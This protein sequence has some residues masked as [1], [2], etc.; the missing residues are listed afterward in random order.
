M[1]LYAAEAHSR[2]DRE[3]ILLSRLFGTL[4][5]LDRETYLADLM[6]RSGIEV[7]PAE[8]PSVQIQFWPEI[9]ACSPD[10]VVEGESFLIYVV[11]ACR[12][13]VDRER[14]NLLADG[15]WKLSPRF[16]LLVI[17]DGD[18][19]PPE[20]DQINDAIPAHREAPLRWLGWAAI[21]LSLYNRLKEA[22]DESPARGVAGDLLGLLAAEGR[23]PFVGFET[24][25]LNE[26]REVLPVY[27]TLHGSVGLL[28]SDMDTRLQGE[29]IR[30]ISP[31]RDAAA[32]GTGPAPRSFIAEYVDE[33]WD[34]SIVS[35]G[36]LFLDIDYLTGEVR[37]GFRFNL[38]EPSARALLVEGR[39]RIAEVFRK[40]E[41]VLIRITG[42][43]GEKEPGRDTSLL[44]LLETQDGAGRIEGVEILSIFDGTRDDLVPLAVQSLTAFRNMAISIPLL[45]I[46]RVNGESPFVVAGQ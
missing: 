23:A 5:I 9:G 12:D 31:H 26:Y 3:E 13:Q 27:D 22:P 21:Y 18:E 14:L 33:T 6:K 39:S 46:H 10:V 44:A 15:G 37:T 30:R 25:V 8:Y 42:E 29:G 1:S 41:E 16:H 43:K 35:V 32:D 45:P 38:A 36:G 11:G 4:D 17:T 20:I 24:T 40:N 19:A 2:T 7:P 34:P 28:L